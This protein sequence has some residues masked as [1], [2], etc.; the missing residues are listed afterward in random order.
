MSLNGLNKADRI[1][2]GILCS[3]FALWSIA[4]FIE[5]C[6]TRPKVQL[7]VLGIKQPDKSGPDESSSAAVKP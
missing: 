5:A 4:V 3:A 6:R 7:M 1:F 2:C